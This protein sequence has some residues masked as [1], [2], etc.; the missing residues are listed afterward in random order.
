MVITQKKAFSSSQEA[1]LFIFTGFITEKNV[2]IVAG[3]IQTYTTRI[4]TTVRTKTPLSRY[5][6]SNAY[7][8]ALYLFC[9]LIE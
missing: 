4:V 9:L 6:G 7:L 5:L 3:N 1:V 2:E 8:G